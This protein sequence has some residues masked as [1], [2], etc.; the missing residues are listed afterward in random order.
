MLRRGLIRVGG[1]LSRANLSHSQT[2]PI[3]LYHKCVLVSQLFKYNHVMLGHCGPSLL[4]ASVGRRLHIV[5]ARQLARTVCRSCVTCRRH[6]SRSENQMMGQLPSE[7]VT[8][9]FPFEI[10]GVDYAGPLTVK[11]GHTRKPVLVKAYLAIFVCFS[12]KAVHVEVVEDLSTEDFLSALKRFVARRGLP[13]QIHSDN[14][15]NFVGAKNDLHELYQFLQSSRTNSSISN[16][17]GSS[18]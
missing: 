13:S 15:R 1:R 2:H 6:S 18:G 12:T 14:G 4:L 7:R 8:Q 17:L 11:K 9:H 16:Y 3:V 10:T 5:G